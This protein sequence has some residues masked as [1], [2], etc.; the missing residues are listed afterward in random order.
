MDKIIVFCGYGDAVTLKMED[1]R[2]VEATSEKELRL[3]VRGIILAQLDE[4]VTSAVSCFEIRFL[5]KA[6]Q[7]LTPDET[8]FIN[9]LPPGFGVVTRAG[10]RATHECWENWEVCHVPAGSLLPSGE[11]LKEGEL[12]QLR[13]NW[14]Y[15]GDEERQIDAFFSDKRNLAGWVTIYGEG[16]VGEESGE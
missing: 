5:T 7:R 8:R 13:Y 6:G 10:W 14:N 4:L 11:K 15:P 12:V 3:K 9:S 2:S 1:F 16:V